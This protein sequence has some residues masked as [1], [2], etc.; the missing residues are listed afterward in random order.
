VVVTDTCEEQQ[1]PQCRPLYHLYVDDTGSRLL[2]KLAATANQHSRWFALGGIL[3]REEDEQQCRA[4][5]DAFKAGWPD[6]SEPLHITDMR[7]MRKHFSW[8]DRLSP[9]ERGKFWQAYNTFLGALPVVGMAC[10]VDRLGY[11][12]RGYGS[13]AG[14]A[15]WNLCKTAFN[16]LIERSGKFAAR[17]GRRLRVKY[18]GS[19]RDADQAIRGYW[20]LL[21]AEF[22]LQFD[23]ERSAKYQ[24]LSPAELARTLV[25][26]ERKDKSSPTS[27]P[28]LRADTIQPLLTTPSF[29]ALAVWWMKVFGRRTVRRTVRSWESSTPV[30]TT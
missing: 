20:A 7:A 1:R 6:L 3:V 21:K 17:D 16:I 19:N 8:L 2:D 18:E 15:K 26:L 30:S 29:G 23:A 10:V 13:R 9:I 24:P 25:D 27:T 5:F 11:L 28:L 22:G 12:G 4:M 14:D